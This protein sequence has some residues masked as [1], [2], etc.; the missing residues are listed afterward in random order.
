MLQLTPPTLRTPMVGQT[1]LSVRPRYSNLITT[2]P[3]RQQDPT[4]ASPALDPA[5]REGGDAA[6][7][8]LPVS[9]DGDAM[10][11]AFN[12]RTTWSARAGVIGRAG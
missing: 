5:G 11:A 4:A 3:L 1:A 8:V 10:T 6:T 2:R 7:E 12:P 9:Y